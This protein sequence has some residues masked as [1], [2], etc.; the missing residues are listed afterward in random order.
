MDGYEHS[1]GA[2][3]VHIHELNAIA[4]HLADYCFAVEQVE[5]ITYP[6]RARRDLPGQVEAGST[7]EVEDLLD[8]HPEVLPG[9]RRHPHIIAPSRNGV[10]RTQC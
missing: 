7:A 10:E 4:G 3:N 8:G 5:V 2:V 9:S 6:D 1:F